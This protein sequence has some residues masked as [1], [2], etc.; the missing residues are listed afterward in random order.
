MRLGLLLGVSCL[1]SLLPAC[2]SSTAVDDTPFVPMADDSGVDGVANPGVDATIEEAAAPLEAAVPEASGVPEASTPEAAPMEAGPTTVSVIVVD[3]RGP[4]PGVNV[5]FQD[6]NGN[7]L[8]S[9]TT[10]ANGRVTAA[11][12]DGSQVT[13]LLGSQLNVQVVTFEGVAPGDVLTAHDATDTTFANAQVSLDAL[14]DAA[15]PLGT[16]SYVVDIGNCS[17]AFTA[18]PALVY[19]SPDCESYG[20]FPVLVEAS[21]GTGPIGFTYQTHNVLPLD[22]GVAHVS[23]NG[24]W[25]TTLPTQS[26]GVSNFDFANLTGYMSYSEIADGISFGRPINFGS[27]D[28]GAT[29]SYTVH[30]GYPVAVQNEANQSINRGSEI[31]ISAVATRSA[32]SADGGAASFDMST[33]LPLLDAVTLDSSQPAQ[34]A[35]SWVTEAGS[36]AAANGTIVMVTWSEPVDGGNILQGTWT[37]VAPPTVTAAKAPVLPAALAAWA[38]SP[39]ATFT[40]TPTVIVVQ[41][42]FVSSYAELRA[43]FAGLPAPSSLLYDQFGVGGVV[44]PLP[45]DGTLKLTAITSPGE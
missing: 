33:L 3:D 11:A 5:V 41:G 32:P 38:P 22:G 18:L 44:P 20:T 24:T 4:E 6:A 17:S 27:T 29:T 15:A 10:D 26:I 45:V 12:P 42:S 7:P 16:T 34:P 19:L 14:P 2:F 8:T 43:Q 40:S 13:V 21:N 23:L 30:P 9:A 39:G 37:I 31:A 1:G 36:L 28:G 25:S 35:V